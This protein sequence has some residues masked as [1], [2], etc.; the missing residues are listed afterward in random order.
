M[1]TIYHAAKEHLL[2]EFERSYLQR[3]MTHTHGNVTQAAKLAGKERRAFDKLLRKQGIDKT[4]FRDLTPPD[5]GEPP[6]S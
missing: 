3:V 4:A 6:V 5:G 1:H 2:I